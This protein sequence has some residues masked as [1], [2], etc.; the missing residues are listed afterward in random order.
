MPLAS[1]AEGETNAAMSSWLPGGNLLIFYQTDDIG[2]NIANFVNLVLPACAAYW[3]E[4][5]LRRDD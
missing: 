3:R 2:S 4:A 5:K 1:L